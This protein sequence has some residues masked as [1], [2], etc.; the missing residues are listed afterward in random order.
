MDILK[1][2]VISMTTLVNGQLLDDI[3]IGEMNI[4]FSGLQ[5][6]EQN[7]ESQSETDRVFLAIYL[8]HTEHESN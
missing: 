3:N 1:I 8:N 7:L 4:T 6:L 5:Y 2:I